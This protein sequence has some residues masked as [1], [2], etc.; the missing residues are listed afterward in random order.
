MKNEAKFRK[1]QRAIVDTNYNVA[2]TI[3]NDLLSEDEQNIEYLMSRGEAY[4]RVERYEDGLVDYAKVVEINNKNL[5]ALNNFA[6]ALIRCNRQIEAKKILEYLLELDPNSFDAYINLG[7][8]LQGMRQ[9]QEALKVAFKAIELKPNECIGYNNLG[10]ALGD[11]GLLKEAQ[12]AFKSAV[13]IN[14]DFLL[15]SINLAQ[16]EDKLGNKEEALTIYE[17][18]LKRKNITLNQI[19]LINYYTSFSYLYF[20]ELSKGWDRYEYGF[21]RL[22]PIGALRSV[23]KFVQPRWKGEFLKEKKLL[24][25]R[26]QGLGDEIEFLTCLGDVLNVANSVILECDARLVNIY[27]RMYPSIEVRTEMVGQDRFSLSNDFDLQCPV[28]S[29]P[30]IFRKSVENF[31]IEQVK[32]SP[33]P[34]LVEKFK[35]RMNNKKILIGICWRSGLLSAERN[36][37]YTALIDWKIFLNQPDIQFVN[38]QYGDS[39]DEIQ[40]IERELGISILRWPDLDLKNDLESLIALIS[41]LDCVVTVGTAVSSLSA[42]VG[43][44]TYLVAHKSWMFMGEEDFYPWYSCVTPLLADR[45][46]HVAQKIELLPSIIQKDFSNRFIKDENSD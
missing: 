7:N 46:D 22:L 35:L 4:L 15:S 25:W 27:K 29:L 8:I 45:G 16:I 39:E 32:Y 36:I 41:L 37:H 2:I 33:L 30:G 40:N 9:S 28:G 12:E 10:S 34:D 43:K 38:L 26:E 20:G 23:R 5:V 13:A 17:N 42:A 31:N 11:M 1:A 44:K 3:L 14:P 18:L 24:I 19:D 21:S 6:A